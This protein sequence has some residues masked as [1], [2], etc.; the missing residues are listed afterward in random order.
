MAGA[1][2]GRQFAAQ[3]VGLQYIITNGDAHNAKGRN[4]CND[5]ERRESQLPLCVTGSPDHTP[6]MSLRTSWTTPTQATGLQLRCAR[7]LPTMDRTSSRHSLS[8]DR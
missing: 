4:V 5:I 6:T 1:E 2:I 8:L 3:D 7:Q